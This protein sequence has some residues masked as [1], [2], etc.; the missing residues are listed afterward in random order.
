MNL[1]VSLLLFVGGIKS[2][3]KPA[4]PAQK[5]KA[6]YYASKF[7][8]RMTAFGER[9]NLK[10]FT[11]A[12]RSLPLN[13]LIEVTNLK[14]M[15]SVIVRV[16]DRG[17]FTKGHIVDL[18]HAAAE[19][20][21]LMGKGVTSVTLRVLDKSRVNELVSVLTMPDVNQSLMQPAL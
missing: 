19:A 2:A 13:T 8:G 14:T 17:P 21:G 16:N 3:V 9:V 7:A 5:G 6:T 18:S 11:A 20:I 1:L 12:H 10:A 4:G 15:R